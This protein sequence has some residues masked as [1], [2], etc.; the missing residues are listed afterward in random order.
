QA[1]GFVVRGNDVSG[2]YI[3][4]RFYGNSD[5]NSFTENRFTQN[6]HP[7]DTNGAGTD[8]RWAVNGVGNLWSGQETFDLNGDGIN[9][10]PHRELDLIG[11]LRRDF[12]AIAF[13]SGSPAVKL[14]RFANERAALPGIHSIDDPAPLTPNFWTIRAQR[15]VRQTA[16]K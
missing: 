11:P 1:I 10:L 14:L 5:G 4:I 16:A 3:G 12:P 2:N 13:L 15:A 6:L 7:V 9:D 8:N